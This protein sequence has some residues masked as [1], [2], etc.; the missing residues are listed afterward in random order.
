MRLTQGARLVAQRL[1][2]N[3][4]EEI[5]IR[6]RFDRTRPVAIQGI[7]TER[8]NYRCQYCNFWRQDQYPAEMSTEQWQRALTSLREFIGRYMIQF[9]GGEPFLH[10]GFVDIAAHCHAEGILWGVITNGSALTEGI[11]ERIA[12][13]APLNIDISVDGATPQVH[14]LAR[15]VPGSLARIGEGIGRL[16]RARDAAKQ[17]FAIRIKP[18]VH[19]GNYTTLPDIVRWAIDVGATT[20][21]FAPVRPWTKEV[22]TLLWL[23]RDEHLARLM[24]VVDELEAMRKA[25]AP[26]ETSVDRMRLWPN[27][28]RHEVVLPELAPCRV[29]MRDFH[30]MPDGN[31]RTCWFYPT[32][33]N[34]VTHSAREVWHGE[35]ARAQRNTML[36]CA[37]F[38]SPKCASSCLAHRPLLRDIQ[39]GFMMALRKP[40]KVL[41]RAKAARR[42][43]GV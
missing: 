5:Y 30:I 13:A 10:K 21:D 28:F 14:D 31:V 6:T 41:A 7:V 42:S 1:G 25:G 33:G 36:T 17:H 20:I 23:D 2:Q 24:A 12:A 35:F 32:I 19:R 16:R 8:C 34:L 11:A 40:A 29:G 39:R 15:G 4:R 9:S 26:I 37:S 22:D 43:D 3:L 27:H 38:G 18:T